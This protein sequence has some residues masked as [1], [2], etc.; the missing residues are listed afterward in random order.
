MALNVIHGKGANVFKGDE[1]YGVLDGGPNGAKSVQMV[2][3]NEEHAARRR[4]LNR[5]FPARAHSFNMINELAHVMMEK[6]PEVPTS[7]KSW[8]APVDISTLAR[9]YS[10]DIISKISFGQSLDLLNSEKYR[11]LPMCLERTS[12]FVHWMGFEHHVK[13]WRW[14]LG[15]N[16]PA[17]LGM[18]DAVE[19]QRYGNFVT[20]LVVQ[21]K[22]RM[23]DVEKAA[24]EK[25]EDIFEHLFRAKMFS[26]SDLQADSSLLVAAGADANRLAICAVFF[27]L[28]K[29]PHAMQK[30]VEEIRTTV[31][32]VND[33]SEATLNK[34]KYLKACVDES[35]RMTPPKAA[36]IPRE[37][38]KGGIEIDGIHVPQGMTVGVNVYSLHHDPDIYPEPFAFKPER[39]LQTTDDRRMQAAFSPFF[40]GPRMCPGGTVAYFAIQLAVFHLLYRYDIRFSDDR[41]ENC[42]CSGL[43]RLRREDEYQMNDWIIGFAN[44]PAIQLQ[45]RA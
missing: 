34:M 14:F 27:Y 20:E 17:R 41:P 40:K 8:S 22:A 32:S 2:A 12:V 1:F 23:K 4:V 33:I 18:A 16:L 31:A 30:A 35:L 36:S 28:L 5:A 29:N 43:A 37:V 7:E 3:D 39:W 44:G 10:F 24:D 45:S 42:Q 6:L 19:T 15:T 11:W 26:D 25:S 13:F 38:N 9:W 21:R